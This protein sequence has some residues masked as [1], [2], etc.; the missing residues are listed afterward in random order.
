MT[1]SGLTGA[2]ARDLR[3]PLEVAQRY[4]ELAAGDI[5]DGHYEHITSSLGRMADIID[6]TTALYR[7][8]QADDGMETSGADELARQVWATVETGAATLETDAT[9]VTCD[10]EQLLLL[11]ENLF[12]NAIE[13]GTTGPDSQARQDDMEH[14]ARTDGAAGGGLTIRVGT[15]ADTNGFYV[16]DTGAGIDPGQREVVFEH[17]HSTGEDATG[18]AP[19]TTGRGLIPYHQSLRWERATYRLYAGMPELRCIRN[20][21]LCA[22]VHA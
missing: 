15:L 16:K 18:L 6:D 20:G 8:V 11:F 5:D 7:Q 13:H 17:G 12:R 10:R 9:S 3:N 21:G 2:L 1:V 14:G 22:C 19:A 4:T